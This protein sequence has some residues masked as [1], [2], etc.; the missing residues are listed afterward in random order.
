MVEA[1]KEY[2]G[3]FIDISN[4]ELVDLAQMAEIR[5]YA[6]KTRLISETEHE[7]YLNFIVKGLARKY[8]Y[9][10]KEEIITQKCML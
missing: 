5:T 7:R 2:V 1:L 6:K 9:R 3:R 10:D 4:E 8:F